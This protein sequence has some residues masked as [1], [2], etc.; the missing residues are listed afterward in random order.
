MYKKV[1]RNY[2]WWDQSLFSIVSLL[3]VFFYNSLHSCY[4]I[5]KT[6]LLKV[7]QYKSS[8]KEIYK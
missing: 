5:V 6:K 2:Y 7:Y 3:S 8:Y 4:I 1:N